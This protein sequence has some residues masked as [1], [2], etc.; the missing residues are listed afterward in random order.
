MPT[1]EHHGHVAFLVAKK[2]P[3]PEWRPPYSAPRSMRRAWPLAPPTVSPTI[4][5]KT[6]AQ[7]IRRQYPDD[8]SARRAGACHRHGT[9]DLALGRCPGADT[10]SRSSHRQS[11]SL[12]SANT[13]V[14]SV[15]KLR[16][17]TWCWTT[18]ARCRRPRYRNQQDFRAQTATHALLTQCRRGD[19]AGD[20]QVAL[21]PFSL[22]VKMGPA[23]VNQD[24]II[25]AIGNR[26]RRAALRQQWGQ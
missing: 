3:G 7:H 23:A 5:W 12:R 24:W 18:P 6:K 4:S 26:H 11:R 22:D 13:I 2:V 15:T 16:V 9:V 25:G 17:A 19:H 20:V 1:D 21:I 8:T 10:L 14:R